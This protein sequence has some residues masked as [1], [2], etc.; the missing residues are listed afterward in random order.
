MKS[1][2][3][4]F[5]TVETGRKWIEEALIDCYLGRKRDWYDPYHESFSFRYWYP[6]EIFYDI[7]QRRSARHA[8]NFARACVEI[9]SDER[10]L[11]LRQEILEDLLN[12]AALIRK[13]SV[14]HALRRLLASGAVA[15]AG[16][17]NQVALTIYASGFRMNYR[18]ADMLAF[19]EAA[20]EH[21]HRYGIHARSLLSDY[22]R[23]DAP[24]W[25]RHFLELKDELAHT[26]ELD[27][28]EYSKSNP[29]LWELVKTDFI[30]DLKRYLGGKRFAGQMKLLKEQGHLD[31]LPWLK[32]EA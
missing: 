6:H 31:S 18:D 17:S 28:A 10:V 25:H 24:N 15:R 23:T 14:L 16:N 3:S 27:E 26:S 4:P 30:D 11:L 32:A 21:V 7:Y 19:L 22:A 12:L 29:E 2:K 1:Q 13:K 8:R 20:Q 5:R 9:L